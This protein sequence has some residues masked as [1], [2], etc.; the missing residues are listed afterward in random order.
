MTELEL[1]RFPGQY[2]WDHS[3]VVTV[4]G[5]EPDGDRVLARD[6]RGNQ[7][8]IPKTYLNLLPA[9][10]RPIIRRCLN[11]LSARLVIS[12]PPVF[13]QAPPPSPASANRAA[14]QSPDRK[15]NRPRR[16]R[17]MRRN[18]A[19]IQAT[20]PPDPQYRRETV[21]GAQAS[22]EQDYDSLR[23]RVK[24]TAAL[25]EMKITGSCEKI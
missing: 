23:E 15:L 13:P 22:L 10:V 1:N 18:T 11:F 3:E 4:V 16:S 8:L 9:A 2:Q 24:V 14:E 7:Q 17:S 20:W 21:E 6:G 25:W 19:E 5:A 12:P